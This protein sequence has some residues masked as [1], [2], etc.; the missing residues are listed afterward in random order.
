MNLEG[1][2]IENLGS[3]SNPNDAVTYAQLATKLSLTGGVMTGALHMGGKK[4]RQGLLRWG[5][6]GNAASNSNR[7]HCKE[8]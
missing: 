1:K 5:R 6:H 3:G 2:V 7:G 4:C 8:R